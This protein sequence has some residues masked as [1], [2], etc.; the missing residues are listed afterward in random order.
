[1]NLIRKFVHKNL[2]LNKKRTIVT[3]IGITLAVALLSALSTMVFS[4]HKSLIEFE[5][6][7]T[8]NFHVAIKEVEK[9]NLSDICNNR[10]IESYFTIGEVGY[11]TI[12]ES[13]NEYKPYARIVETDEAGYEGASFKLIEGRFPENDT[14]IV[15]PRHLKT[16]G[17]VE[18]KI[19]E[20]LELE[21][22]KRVL[23]EDD[24]PIAAEL[25]YT[26]EEKIIDT[27]TKKYTVVGIIERPAY[28]I[29][30]YEAPG[31]TFVTKISKENLASEDAKINAYVRF[32]RQGLQNK[33]EVIAGIIDVNPYLY[34]KANSSSEMLT[35]KESEA[36]YREM[37]SAKYQVYLNTW[38]MRYETVW[39]IDSSMLVLFILAIIVAAII[40]ITSVYCIKNSFD[41]SIS[42][43][44]RQYGML[45]SIGA[46]KKQIKKSVYTEAA[47][48]GYVGIFLGVVFGL[49]AGF[50]LILISNTLLGRMLQFSLIFNPSILAILIAV[51]LGILTIF[52]SA[53]GSARKA[54]KV[55][56]MEAIRN[57]NEIKIS[58][59]K[60]KTPA[61][62]SKIWGIGG[63]I[64]YKNIKRNK[65]KYRTT[66][67]SIVIC[68]VTFIVISYF[69]SMAM[70]LVGMA[71]TSDEYN[72]SANIDD[73]EAYK[74]LES[75][76][77]TLENVDSYT[78][79]KNGYFELTDFNY[80]KDLEEKIE[81]LD[82]D[83][84]FSS[85]TFISL[86][87]KS[88][89]KYLKECGV[90]TESDKAVLVNT[91]NMEWIED[92]K[93]KVGQVEVFGY[94][95]G[96]KVNFFDND[97]SEAKFDE[98]DNVIPETIKRTDYDLEIAAVSDERPVGY[99]AYVSTPM[100]VV[101][102]K[103]TEE[104]GINFRDGYEI[105]FSSGNPD[106]LQD[107]LEKFS[108][109][110]CSEYMSIYNRDKNAQNEK[111]LFLLLEIFAYGLITVIALIGITN[112][113]NTLG[114]SMEL[115]S[116]DF[117][118]L[119]SIG[120]TDKQFMRMVRLESLFTSAKALII[121]VTAGMLISYVIN[122][123]EC[124]YDTVIPFKPPIMSAILVILVVM[125]LIYVIIRTSLM[126]I[127]KRNIID[128]IKNENI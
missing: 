34:K 10:A 117:A 81:T 61:Y 80:S 30:S 59:K 106:K 45:S 14:E 4:F 58:S 95:K 64:S 27:A 93:P 5:K 55:S 107:D 38:L 126:R 23:S 74:V 122:R 112:I 127:N 18:Y 116:R 43:K 84:D 35:A 2:M 49:F 15:I 115:R 16:N 66:V 12:E 40:I 63:V 125:L 118:T 26:G 87:E 92:E 8:G 36:Y 123:M 7:K 47:I 91:I 9:N 53:A 79:V 20:T 77:E 78:V 73:E 65:K 57:Q 97:Y 3:I 103:A 76:L 17:R 13:K 11:A 121:G 108:E 94:K 114:T 83:L 100:L 68:T 120:M 54:A 52:L 89:Q 51:V 1:M 39:P 70:E 28:G 82:Y 72:I 62:I 98:N 48:M 50:V 109:T 21:V 60:I 111:S 104:K 102:E 67:V 75:Q 46:T 96:D 101:S 69:M 113:I 86:D 85:I 32:D 29:E 124:R 42:E 22:G 90:N 110:Y 37:E 33:D 31:Y 71:Y 25:Q 88:F 19:G 6:N 99:K 128:T 119:R 24:S 41:I 44:I 105:Y 56:P